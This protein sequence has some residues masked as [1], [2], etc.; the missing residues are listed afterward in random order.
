MPKRSNASSGCPVSVWVMQDQLH[1]GLASLVDAPPDAPVLMIENRAWADEVDHHKQKLVLIYSA[2]RHFAQELVQAG[3]TVD[4]YALGIRRGANGFH[5]TPDGD[6]ARCLADHAQR[7][8]TRVVRMVEPSEYRVQ[9]EVR[10]VVDPLGLSLELIPN[11]LFILSREEFSEWDR[12]QRELVMENFYRRMRARTGILLDEDGLPL[13]GRWNFDL[14]NRVPPMENMEFTPPPSVE[15]DAIT[16]QVAAMVE[17]EFAG[18][19][20]STAGFNWPVT[21]RDTRA[22][23]Q[24]FLKHRLRLFGMYQDAMV[25]DSWFMYH[26][27][28]SPMLNLGLIH[29]LECARAAEHA[30]LSGQVPINSAE[31]FIRQLI[32]WREYLYG[33]YW[34]RMPEYRENNYFGFGRDVPELVRHGRTKMTCLKIVLEQTRERGYAHHIQRLMIVGNLFL[35]LGVDP[36]RAIDWFRGA[37]IDAND[38]ATVPNVLGMLYFADAGDIG[39]KPYAVSANYISKMSDY[40]AKC[41]YRSRKRVGVKSCPYNFLYW[42]FLSEHHDKLKSNKRM[43]MVL[44]LLRKKSPG[45]LQLIKRYSQD[46][47]RLLAERGTD[48]KVAG[49]DHAVLA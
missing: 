22:W 29:P 3:R 11:N 8:G 36:R 28:L 2:M 30:Y 17:A 14:E 44:N 37:Y 7:H 9:A 33:V 32:G 47:M 5:P 13:E 27:L 39:S 16:R 38:W 49:A 42:N 35:L 43:S 46:F 20:G 12:S 23:F 10:R 48:S 18:H 21:A 40:C 25:K 24:D 19:T 45:E 1:H 26:S 6:F 31:G 4:Y 34:S 41:H 15:P